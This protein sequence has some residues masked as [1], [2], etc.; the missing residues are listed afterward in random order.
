MLTSELRDIDPTI[1]YADRQAYARRENAALNDYIYEK[2]GR[3]FMPTGNNLE[4]F[5]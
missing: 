2:S 5:I 3:T 4:L 1:T